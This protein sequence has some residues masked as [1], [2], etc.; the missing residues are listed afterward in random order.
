MQS[1]GNDHGRGYEP[2]VNRKQ[3]SPE[4]VFPPSGVSYAE[5]ASGGATS[6]GITSSGDVYAWGY[7]KEG[8][9]GDGSTKTAASP[10]EVDTGASLISS[11]A[12]NVTVARG[13]GF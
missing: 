12:G 8:E 5:L 7:N 4:Q 2:Q 11:T 13:D 9:V 10:V 6:Y 1:E 3:A